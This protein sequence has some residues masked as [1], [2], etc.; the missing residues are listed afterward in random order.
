MKDKNI[1]FFTIFFSLLFPCH[2]MEKQKEVNHLKRLREVCSEFNGERIDYLDKNICKNKKAKI[3][4]LIEVSKE[5]YQNYAN[6]NE[7][8]SK[9]IYLENFQENILWRILLHLSKLDRDNLSLV[10]HSFLSG[11]DENVNHIK[12]KSQISSTFLENFLNRHKN[13]TSINI[14]YKYI[15]NNLGKLLAHNT[16]LKYLN[17]EG[18]KI[19]DNLIEGLASNTTL[20]TLNLCG[21]KINSLASKY[22]RSNTTLKHL[23]LGWSKITESEI[24][25]LASN[26]TLITLD[27]CGSN[28]GKAGVRALGLNSTLTALN[29]SNNCINKSLA[30]FSQNNTMKKLDLGYNWIGN[31][32]AKYLSSNT[33]LTEL[34]LCGNKIGNKGAMYL[35]FNSKLIYLNILENDIGEKGK[36]FFQDSLNP[37]LHKIKIE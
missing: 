26:T 32:G 15:D 23:Y 31:K 13:L 11:V 1:A 12:F 24:I 14:E 20:I 2:T 33:T 8:I 29:L 27:L 25:D 5:D 30:T 35:S 16:T 28:A 9:I 37:N 17:L 22:F 21:S 6:A 34:N 7:I 19:S 3:N 36:K 10:C 4:H 18:C